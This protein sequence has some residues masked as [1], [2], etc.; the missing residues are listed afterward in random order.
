M[1]ANWRE[2]PARKAMMGLNP[3]SGSN[4]HAHQTYRST[5]RDSNSVC[6]HS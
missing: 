2:V 6:S 5:P 1:K 4:D 3:G